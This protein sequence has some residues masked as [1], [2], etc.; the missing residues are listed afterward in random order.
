[1]RSSFWLLFAVVFSATVGHLE[2]V[3]TIPVS[4][5]ISTVCRSVFDG[6]MQLI[7]SAA[8]TI[9]MAS[10]YVIFSEGS[11]GGSEFGKQILAALLEALKR[12]VEVRVMVPWPSLSANAQTDLDTLQ[13]AGA[14]IGKFNWTASVGVK[15]MFHAKFM[16]VDSQHTYVGSA[17]YS[18]SALARIKQSGI[19]VW[20]SSRFALDANRIFTQ[21][22]NVING[23][24]PPQWGSND[25]AL[26]NRTN[27]DENGAFIAES[28]ESFCASFREPDAVSV[29]SAVER[30]NKFVKLASMDYYTA[31]LYQGSPALKWPNLD[32]AIRNASD[33]GVNIYILF[34][35]WEQSP[36]VMF[37]VWRSLANYSTK[38]EIRILTVPDGGVAHEKFI[39]T[40]V[41]AY[42][43]TNNMTPD[44]YLKDWTAGVSV[45][46]KS[47]SLPTLER[48]FDRDWHSS[49]AIPIDVYFNWT[50][51]I[52]N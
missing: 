50:V 1:M 9:D 31:T 14:L 29:V 33:R 46:M 18:W 26:T 28:P 40:D 11:G 19:V 24:V 25:T 8:K 12:G 27:T 49:Y 21:Y 13:T 52:K 37:H 10:L 30:A 43:S 6:W 41:D 15:G 17:D 34:G 20:S 2:L 38:I 36:H 5:N 51:P 7:T 44:Y 23:T 32:D 42:V 3:E 47:S 39:V 16:I 45:T 48:Y 4:M 22:W 35:I